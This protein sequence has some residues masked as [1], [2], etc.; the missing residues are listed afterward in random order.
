MK[1]KVLVLFSGGLDSVLA[2]CKIVEEGY[3]AILVYYDNGCGAGSENV[4]KTADRVIERYGSE[5]VE[6]WGIGMTVGYFLALRHIYMN[7]TV[8][9]LAQKYPNLIYNQV[10][11]LACRT[12]MYI[13]SILICKKIGIKKIAEGARIDQLF[14]IEQEVMLNEY[15]KLLKEYDIELL[16]PVKDLDSDYKRE[17]ELM[18]RQISPKVLEPKCFLGVPMNKKLTE[19]ELMDTVKYYKNELDSPCRELIKNS[20][21]IPID[22]RGKMF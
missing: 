16:T 9:N 7:E 12:S 5:C 22:N 8:E 6:F 1:E 19:E 2:T 15:R 10:N 13:Y 17:I 20:K 14:A 21:K 11:C 18:I 3:K 4:K